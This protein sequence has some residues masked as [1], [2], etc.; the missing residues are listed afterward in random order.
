LEN[1]L[2]NGWNYRR[3]YLI[4]QLLKLVMVNIDSNQYL[5]RTELKNEIK[6]LIRNLGIQ[7]SK[8]IIKV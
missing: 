3:I 8:R 1:L 4:D 6:L 7:F 5:M 2:G